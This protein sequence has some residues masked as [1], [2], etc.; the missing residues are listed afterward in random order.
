M[1]DVRNR[2]LPSEIDPSDGLPK[3]FTGDAVRGTWLLID[4]RTLAEKFALFG[5]VAPVVL[6]R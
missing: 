4:S 1:T 2:G 5:R 3:R 6:A